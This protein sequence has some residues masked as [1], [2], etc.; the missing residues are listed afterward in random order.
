VAKKFAFVVPFTE[1]LS[2]G[3]I[4]D[5]PHAKSFAY[6]RIEIYAPGNGCGYLLRCQ[7]KILFR[8]FIFVTA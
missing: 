2:G 3:G 8:T 4:F 5:E 1:Q 7:I 6:G